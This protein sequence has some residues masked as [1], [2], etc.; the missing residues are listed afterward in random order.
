MLPSLPSLYW[1][2]QHC[3]ESSLYHL[4]SLQELL[5]KCHQCMEIIVCAKERQAAEANKNATILLE[6]IDQERSR[7]ESKRAAAARKREKKRQKKKEKQEQRESQ[8]KKKNPT[9]EPEEKEEIEEEEEEENIKPVEP[10]HNK[11][12]AKKTSA[13]EPVKVA[14]VTGELH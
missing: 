12:S 3:L 11:K 13:P 5:K 10:S 4:L 14:N 7:E 2:I 6:E 9:P 1:K 8:E